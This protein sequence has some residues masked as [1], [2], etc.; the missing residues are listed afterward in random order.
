MTEVTS[1]HHKSHKWHRQPLGVAR[2]RFGR[3]QAAQQQMGEEAGGRADQAGS[4]GQKAG[5][6]IRPRKGIGVAFGECV[7]S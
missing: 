6:E 1:L 3:K 7:H 5:Q 2:K 4:V